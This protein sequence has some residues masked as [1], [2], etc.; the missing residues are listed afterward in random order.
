MATT[1]AQMASY[2]YPEEEDPE[3]AFSWWLSPCGGTDLV[4]D[5]IKEIFGV[6]SN[7]ADGISSFKPPKK[8]PKGSGKKGD[9]ANPKDQST[10]KSPGKG[11]GNSRPACKIPASKKTQRIGGHTLREQSC[12]ADKTVMNEW[13]VTSLN[14]A[15]NA[16]PTK[17]AKPCLPK[18]SQACYHYS[19][20]IRVNPA[21]ATLTCPP[22][23]AQTKKAEVPRRVVSAWESQHRGKGWRDKA[24]RPLSNCQADE[25]PP[26]YLLNDQ[27]P[28]YINAGQNAQGQLVRFLPG[29]QNGGAA[30]MWKSEC[31]KGP[32]AALS[33]RDLKDKVSADP[34]SR[35]VDQVR[36]KKRY[37]QRIGSASVNVRPE[38]SISSWP[39]AAPNDGMLVNQCWPR[40]APND[41]GFTLLTF[42]PFYQGQPPPYNYAAAW[43]PPNNG[44]P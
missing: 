5:E 26:V 30:S 38:F 34:N 41:P 6:L 19:S 7:V 35:P 8:I 17:V 14:Y 29:P 1:A 4:P 21:W 43:D 40:I 42:D 2:I 37:I 12:V 10:P 32:A 39:P 23:A 28:A 11:S 24:N 25:Y 20:A 13:I 27:S 44:G 22:E 33:D 18:W 9:P 31:F 3:G 16:A 15:A 36:N